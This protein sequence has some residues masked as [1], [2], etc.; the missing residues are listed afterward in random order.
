MAAIKAVCEVGTHGVG[1]K[2]RQRHVAQCNY[3]LVT[4]DI[5]RSRVGF[6]IDELKLNDSSRA[7]EAR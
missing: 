4:L 1:Q 7:A 2:Q 6:S 3:G 5:K